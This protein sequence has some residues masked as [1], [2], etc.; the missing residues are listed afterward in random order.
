M[1]RYKVVTITHKTAK[2]NRLKDYLLTD[3][4]TSDFPSNRLKELKESFAIDEL[5]YLNTCNRV[6]FF[7]TCRVPRLQ[8][9]HRSCRQLDQRSR[10][11][12]RHQR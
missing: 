11:S 5:L 7:F 1:Q 10:Q 2:V 4:D 12:Y 6:T 3:A 8:G 9:A